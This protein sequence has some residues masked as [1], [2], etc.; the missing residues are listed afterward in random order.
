MYVC[1]RL[2]RFEKFKVKVFSQ[3]IDVKYFKSYHIGNTDRSGYDR[4]I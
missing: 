1:I 3:I 4:R 2:A